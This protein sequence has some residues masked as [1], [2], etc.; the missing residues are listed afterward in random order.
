[1]KLS[2]RPSKKLGRNPRKADASKQTGSPKSRKAGAPKSKKGGQPGPSKASGYARSRPGAATRPGSRPIPG[3]SQLEPPTP[4]PQRPR[5]PVS[6]NEAPERRR[7]RRIDYDETSMAPP[8][9]LLPRTPS[10]PLPEPGNTRPDKTSPRSKR[11]TARQ[12]AELAATTPHQPTTKREDPLAGTPLFAICGRPNVG[13]STL[14]NKLTESR[15][16]IVGDEPGITRDRIYG[17][18]HWEGRVARIVDTGGIVPDDAALIPSEI[19]RQASFAL[20]ESDC[21]VMV[22]D[23]RTE[24]ASPDYDLAKQLLRSGKPL[25]L[26]VNKI[27]TAEM[28]AAAENYR[29][30]GFKTIVPVSAEHSIGIGDLLDEVFARLKFPELQAP[31]TTAAA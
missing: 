9:K 12:K 3:N 26:A 13:K 25:I 30:L 20:N 14:F 11:S 10:A 24:L 8:V 31:G 28:A 27:D 22:V 2:K 29:R 16:S 15:R 18:V 7:A 1:M 17:E 19:Y 21:I 4:A 23:G 6:V 5:G